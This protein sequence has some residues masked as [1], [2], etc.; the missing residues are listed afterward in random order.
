MTVVH[1]DGDWRLPTLSVSPFDGTTVAALQVEAP[2]GTV[3]AVTVAT[4][5][6]GATWT[7]ANAYQFTASGEW[8]E[9]WT[10][11]G[12]G[13]S[14]ERAVL[15]VQPDPTAAP[16][17]QIIYATTTDYAKTGA[18]LFAGIR[19]ALREASFVIDE[20][21]LTAVYV[22]DP[23]TH[24]PTVA[25]E[26][27]AVRDATCAQVEYSKT[28][29]DKFAIGSQQWAQMA[30]GTASLARGTNMKG[31]VLPGRWSPKAFHFLQQAGLTA[32]GPQPR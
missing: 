25:A 13:E 29:G 14:K 22:V 3:T 6:S 17:G 9:R 11:T 7:A 4:V 15:L 18:T 2:D 32:F 5:D 28:I 31:T 30:I 16:S 21:L 12:M 8:V 26:L 10:V 23:V 1:E 20:M 27:Q 19:R 24:L